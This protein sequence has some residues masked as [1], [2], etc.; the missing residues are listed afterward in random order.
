MVS[1]VVRNGSHDSGNVTLCSDAIFSHDFD[2][3]LDVYDGLCY[4]AIRSY[5]ITTIE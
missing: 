1:R 4:V 3:Q 2:L 5:A